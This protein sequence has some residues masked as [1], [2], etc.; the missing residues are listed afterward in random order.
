MEHKDVETYDGQGVDR[1]VVGTT[2]TDLN[3]QLRQLEAFAT[4]HGLRS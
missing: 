4:L 3:K 1:P 2:S